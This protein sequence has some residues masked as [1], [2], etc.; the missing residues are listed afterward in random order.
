MTLYN[1]GSEVSDPAIAA[2]PVTRLTDLTVEAFVS[3]YLQK[4]QP[5][6][7]T[8][9]MRDWKALALWEPGH[10]AKRFGNERVQVYGDLFRL[11]NI[12][13]LSEYF[14]KYFGRGSASGAS[15]GPS[16]IPYVRWYC[17]LADDERVPWADDVFVQL[18]EDWSRPAFFPADSF[19]LPFC[20]PSG[21]IDP[22][23][24]WF[25]ARGLFIS[26]QGART[27]LH[28]DPW[29]SDALLCQIYGKKGFVM[30]DP[31][32]APYLTNA[33]KAIDIEKP[34][35]QMFP[36]FP[37]ARATVC[38]TLHPGEIILVPAGWHHHFKSTTD[39]ISLTWNFVHLS[40]LGEFLTY[41]GRGPAESEL[42]QL[43]YAYFDSPAHHPIEGSSFIASLMK[44]REVASQ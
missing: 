9:A 13:P 32:Q 6:I 24:N 26:A 1:L 19:A 10:L 14:D 16:S 37:Q 23:R 35:L 3:E 29:A 5:V 30:Y 34:D 39:S 31:S 11:A 15:S 40:R 36:D 38:D 2:P 21:K 43:A 44:W 22:S 4:N 41:L 17:H 33:G 28:A 12:T 7:V 42:K 8:D 18:S 20:A 25:P 27:R